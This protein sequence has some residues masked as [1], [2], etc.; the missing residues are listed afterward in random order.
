MGT[1][2]GEAGT[3]L[4]TRCDGV[5]A[6]DIVGSANDHNDDDAR[7]GPLRWVEATLALPLPLRSA[8][9][10]SNKTPGSADLSS[11]FRS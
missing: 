3:L 5:A 6:D 1:L 10:A 4:Q 9:N 8:K 11:I 2:D 7:V